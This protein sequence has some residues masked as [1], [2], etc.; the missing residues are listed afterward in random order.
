[1]SV[2]ALSV[3]SAQKAKYLLSASVANGAS[4]VPIGS[5]I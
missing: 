2:V 4:V 3:G 5:N 1:M